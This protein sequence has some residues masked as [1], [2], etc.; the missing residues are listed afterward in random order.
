MFQNEIDNLYGQ[1]VYTFDKTQSFI[2]ASENNSLPSEINLLLLVKTIYKT[3]TKI[4]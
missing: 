1:E 2:L 4:W 3:W